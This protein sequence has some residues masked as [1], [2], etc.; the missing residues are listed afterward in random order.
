MKHKLPS[1]DA[2]KVFESAARHL[3]FSLA[4]Q[5]LCLTKGAVSYQIRKLEQSLDCALFRRSIRQVYLTKAGQRLLQTTQHLFSELTHTLEQIKPEDSS[6]DVIIGATTYVAMRWLSSRIS[7]F[8]EQHP[9]VSILL[10]HSVNSDDFRI[11]DV[12]FAIR[13]DLMTGSN[14]RGLLLELPMPLFPVCSPQLLLRCGLPVIKETFDVVDLSAAKLTSTPLLCEDRALDLWQVWYGKQRRPLDNP[15]RVIADAN[16]RTQAAIDGQGWTL[17]DA[18]MQ[19]ELDSGAL[20]AP[21][22][23][24][25]DGYGYAIQTYPGRF[26]SQ[27]ALTLRKWLVDHV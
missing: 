11:Q 26:V 6:H 27:I 5:E 14:K 20:V 7:G 21:F 19:R 9:E 2:L 25:L 18:L 15:R 23:H 4:A 1:L 8:N 16:V 22:A 12:D 17:A 3:S 24:R 13:W 10:Q